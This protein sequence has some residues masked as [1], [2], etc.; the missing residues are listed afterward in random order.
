[1]A[2]TVPPGAQCRRPGPVAGVHPLATP[3]YG[4]ASCLC[5]VPAL[6]RRVPLGDCMV[7]G[8]DN[9]CPSWLTNLCVLGLVGWGRV[10]AG[11]TL[12]RAPVPPSLSQPCRLRF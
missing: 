7:P 2:P 6:R 3:G 5:K 8:Q 10:R 1:M 12:I 11:E 4:L 9:D